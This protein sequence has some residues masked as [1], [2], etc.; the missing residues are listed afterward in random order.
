MV[1][2]TPAVLASDVPVRSVKRSELMVRPVVVRL[3]VV[4]LVE[5]A[6]TNVRLVMVEVALLTR[7]P[8]ENVPRAE[9]VRP[10]KV[11]E[12]EVRMS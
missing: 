12:S 4:A 1:F 2:N 9:R 5:V 8:P 10:V 11:G 6:F 7:M 3:V